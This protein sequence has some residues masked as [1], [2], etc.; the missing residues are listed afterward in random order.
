MNPQA[1]TDFPL[2]EVEVVEA[3]HINKA[4]L[5]VVHRVEGLIA[6]EEGVGVPPDTHPSLTI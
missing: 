3:K 5:V 6:P 2:P 4:H 1:I